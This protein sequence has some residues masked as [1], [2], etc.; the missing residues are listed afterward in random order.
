MLNIS[1][2]P[3][4]K[5]STDGPAALANLD[6]PGSGDAAGESF[7]KILERE[8]STN[9]SDMAG[10]RQKKPD[11][12]VAPADDGASNRNSEAQADGSGSTQ[13]LLIDVP[14][15]YSDAMLK[16]AEIDG[17][18]AAA[19]ATTE[20]MNVLQGIVQPV[21]INTLQQILVS[22]HDKSVSGSMLPMASQLLQQNLMQQNLE[23]S[24]LAA[25]A[26]D[27]LQAA[28][29]EDSAAFGK[30]LPLATEM[31]ETLQHN[32]GDL[33]GMP[34]HTVAAQSF[35]LNSATPAALMDPAMEK[36]QVDTPVGHAKWGGELAQKVVWMASQQSQVA[37]IHLNPAHLGPVEVM[38]NISQDQATAQFVSANPAV[39]DAIQDALPK[40]REML[41]DNGIQL[42]NVTVGADS[43]QQEHRQQ[44][45]Y[46]AERGVSSLTDLHPEVAELSEI[47]VMPSRHQGMVNT[48][49]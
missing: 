28:E 29:L 46:H 7:G 13:N 42:G 44:H 5:S 9:Q 33:P 1:V 40:L 20:T 21:P 4:I 23:E 39:R 17:N 26:N 19:V 6:A 15:A 45:A 30:I 47:P 49:A 41:A 37:E 18:A 22:Q 31:T 48:Y 32:A 25:L 2:I 43:F 16:P 10:E 35:G 14:H 34:E 24:G 36:V 12:A 27:L 11:A 8:V 3:Q 38:L